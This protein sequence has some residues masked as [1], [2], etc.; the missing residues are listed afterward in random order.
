MTNREPRRDAS[1]GASESARGAD[2]GFASEG[3]D[4]ELVRHAKSLLEMEIEPVERR[5]DSSTALQKRARASRHR[6]NAKVAYAA[7]RLDLVADELTVSFALDPSSEASLRL[8]AALHHRAGRLTEAIRIWQELASRSPGGSSALR[9]LS[10]VFELSLLDS[11]ARA[12]SASPGLE[13][14]LQGALVELEQSFRL[15]FDG[16]LQG[17]LRAVDKVASRSRST[18]RQLYKIASIQRAWLLEQSHDV[19]G[20]IAT[21]ERLADEPGLAS[22][23]ERLLCLSMLYE[24]EGTP[25][26]IR[27]AVR[28]VRHA[29]VVTGQPTLLRR[30]ARLLATLGHIRLAS[31]FERRYGDVFRRRM[32]GVTAAEIARVASVFYVPLDRLTPSTDTNE[33][34]QARIDAA[35]KRVRP[36]HRIR[37]AILARLH[38]DAPR[39]ESILRE[40]AAREEL[41]PAGWLHLADLEQ[42]SGSNREAAHARRRAIELGSLEASA[43]AD[44]LGREEPEFEAEITTFL[45]K[46]GSATRAY[47]S[48]DAFAAVEPRSSK[49]FLAMSRLDRAAGRVA[50]ADDHASRAL[51]MATESRTTRDR[52]VLAAAA[53]RRGGEVHGLIH[54][55][56]VDDRRTNAGEGGGLDPSEVLGA[57][58]P[59][60]RAYAISVF[61]TV[62]AY[63]EAR[64]PHRLRALAD[65]R[66]V[67]KLT[68]DDEPSSGD[69]AGLPIAIAFL[70]AFFQLP[71]PKDVA[72]S[73]AIVCDAHDVVMIGRV[74]DVEAKVEGAYER[75]LGRLFLPAANRVDVERAERVPRDVARELVSYA[76][77]LDDV[78]AAVFPSLYP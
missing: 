27:R 72:M 38:S 37:A 11:A 10:H 26:R 34:A 28:A 40:L 63:A 70:A 69:S 78:C 5:T 67:L 16:N 25:E 59:E 64:Y 35:L 31:D 42:A 29:Y 21:M 76:E 51:I 75:R 24:R 50:R 49:S 41:T 48:L 32:H 68:K 71:I 8:L 46:S 4:D 66:F 45:S 17:A 22:D 57:V 74:G 44:L 15:A 56:W 61:H 53:L 33:A 18:D 3:L 9:Q 39:A 1:L 13:A 54:E 12:R 23:T 65:R 47:R 36:A 55:L 62:K 7:G 52:V 73:G 43:V 6:L 2:D 30:L 77:T 60:L 58:S 20:A 19:P 14:S